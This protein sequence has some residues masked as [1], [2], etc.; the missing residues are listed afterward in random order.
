MFRKQL[1]ILE[2][3]LQFDKTNVHIKGD[4]VARQIDEA[5]VFINTIENS[6]SAPELKTIYKQV[7]IYYL[8]HKRDKDLASHYL[9]KFKSLT[10]AQTAEFAEACNLVGAAYIIDGGYQ[11]DTLFKAAIDAY[12]THD[13]TRE[14]QLG[15]AYAMRYIGLVQHRKSFAN[16]N[17]P[18]QIAEFSSNAQYAFETVI[19]IQQRLQENFPTVNLDLAESFHLLGVT[20]TRQNKL[21]EAKAALEEA[22]R[23]WDVFCNDTHSVHPIKFITMQSLGNILMRLGQ[24]KDAL[25]LLRD[26]YQQQVT[27]YETEEHADIAKTWHFIGDIHKNAAEYTLANAAYRKALTIKEKLYQ[28]QAASPILKATQDAITEVSPKLL[29]ELAT[30][31]QFNWNDYKTIKPYEAKLGE[32][33]AAIKTLATSPLTKEENCILAEHQTQLGTY[34]NHVKRDPERAWEHLNLAGFNIAITFQEKLNA[35]IYTLSN[36]AAAQPLREQTD[37]LDYMLAW[38]HNHHAFTYQ[39]QLAAAKKTKNSAKIKHCQSQIAMITEHL[40]KNK[41]IKIAAFAYCVKAL[42]QYEMG[43]LNEA[44][45]TYKTALDMYEKNNACDDQYARAKNRWAMMLAENKQTAEAEQAFTELEKYWAEDKDTN[46]PYPAR[47]FAVYGEHLLK[48]YEET[49]EL[50]HLEN[51]VRKFRAADKDTNN[52]YPARFFAVYGEHLLKRY[53]ETKELDHL[54]N[55]VRKFRAADKDTNNPYPARFFAVYGEH[56][57]KRYEETKELDHLE[58]AVRKFRAAHQILCITDGENAGYT[59][60]AKQKLQDAMDAYSRANKPS[61][62]LLPVERK[63]LEALQ[64]APATS[65]G[66]R[67]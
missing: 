35:S 42:M 8:F 18:A 49:K 4:E 44:I 20:L 58:N 16:E 14:T 38:N 45:A 56:L 61:S 11:D 40:I 52:P 57:L 22:A 17:T 41:D 6:A 36:A 51:A 5:I 13:E 59:K 37:K 34:Y 28:D 32:I 1:E 62:S 27:Y 53:E 66:L 15:I 2:N 29:P 64:L 19:E 25:A 3:V 10:T 54:E 33:E 12:P 60:V 65:S 30:L 50:D 67:Q 26:A 47:F 55:A 9:E 23:L 31:P 7:G 46:N 48:R 43:E 21:A 63:E 39:Q 24:H